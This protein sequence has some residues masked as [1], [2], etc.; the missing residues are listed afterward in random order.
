MCMY[1]GYF[2]WHFAICNNIVWSLESTGTAVSSLEKKV[3][4]HSKKQ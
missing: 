2:S 4:E 3:F 1:V